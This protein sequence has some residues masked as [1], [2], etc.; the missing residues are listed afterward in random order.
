MAEYSDFS[1]ILPE[2]LGRMVLVPG[3][4]SP[5]GSHDAI[6]SS[7]ILLGPDGG[8]TSTSTGRVT[9]PSA[10]WKRMYPS[11]FRGGPSALLNLI[12]PAGT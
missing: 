1:N 2:I 11:I 4:H 12:A 7:D 5:K 8:N 9:S 3:K 6:S 10:R